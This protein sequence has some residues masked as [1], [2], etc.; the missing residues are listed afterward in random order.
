MPWTASPRGELGWWSA[1]WVG[2]ER[3]EETRDGLGASVEAELLDP[4][5]SFGGHSHLPDDAARPGGGVLGEPADV[6]TA[7]RARRVDVGLRG[8]EEVEHGARA[9]VGREP[10]ALFHGGVDDGGQEGGGG[11]HG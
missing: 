9:V 4:R 11:V 6:D 2:D 10:G 1:A 7:V 3:G 5:V 8:V